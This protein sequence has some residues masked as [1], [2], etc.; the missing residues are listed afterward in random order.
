MITFS[1]YYIFKLIHWRSSCWRSTAS[2]QSSCWST[3]WILIPLWFSLPQIQG[4]SS[5]LSARWFAWIRYQHSGNW[6]FAMAWLGYFLC[7]PLSMIFEV[8]RQM[9]TSLGRFE[10]SPSAFAVPSSVEHESVLRAGVSLSWLWSAP[11]WCYSDVWPLLLGYPRPTACCFLGQFVRFPLRVWHFQPS[12]VPFWKLGTQVAAWGSDFLQHIDGP[13]PFAFSLA[14][15]SC[16]QTMIQPSTTRVWFSPRL[17]LW[18]TSFPWPRSWDRPSSFWKT[19]L[20]RPSH[21]V[22]HPPV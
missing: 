20:A 1:H 12:N 18:P 22:G 21:P 8:A 4:R 3:H 15:A 6:G 10:E 9:L 7:S 5:P 17:D 2:F 16:S 14:P 11:F 13:V 19:Y